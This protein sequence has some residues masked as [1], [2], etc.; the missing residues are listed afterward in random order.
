MHTCAA[1]R[2]NRSS[3]VSALRYGRLA[4]RHTYVAVTG[5]VLDLAIG[6]HRLG[7]LSQFVHFCEQITNACTSLFIVRKFGFGVLR[8]SSLLEKRRLLAEQACQF[9]LDLRHSV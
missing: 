8:S 9:T 6:A 3:T 7:C 1:L 4:A 5:Y 2:T